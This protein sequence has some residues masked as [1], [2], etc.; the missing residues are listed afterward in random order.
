MDVPVL[1]HFGT[2]SELKLTSLAMSSSVSQIK[3]HYMYD[4][5]RCQ[6]HDFNSS[7]MTQSWSALANYGQNCVKTGSKLIM[8]RMSSSRRIVPVVINM[9]CKWPLCHMLLRLSTSCIMVQHSCSMVQVY[10]F[11]YPALYVWATELVQT[12]NFS[13]QLCAVAAE[14]VR[15]VRAQ[16]CNFCVIYMFAW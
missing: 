1:T 2:S 8:L 12:C 5:H 10:D 9:T 4:S 11:M 15:K 14:S 6:D 7:V 3:Y 16:F 13:V